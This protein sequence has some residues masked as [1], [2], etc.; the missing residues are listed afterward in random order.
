M[1]RSRNFFS[2]LLPAFLMFIT[3][4]V[5]G[6]AEE[7][8]GYL[9]PMTGI[10]TRVSVDSNG[11]QANLWSDYPS[12][13]GDGRYIAFYSAAGNLVIDDTNESADI[14][15]HDLQLGQTTR[16]SVASDGTQA[17]PPGSQFSPSISADGRFV[18]FDSWASN[19]VSG[20]TNQM[21]DIFVHDRQ[22]GQ[23]TRISVSSD[24]IEGNANSVLPHISADGRFVVFTSYANNL[25]SGDTNGTSDVFLHDMLTVQTTR[26]S[27]S[28]TGIEGNGRSETSFRMAIS[29]DGQY[30]VFG[31]EADN[32]VIGDTN[33][34]YDVFMHNIITGETA[35]I[36]VSSNGAEGDG[37][38]PS[39]SSDGRYVV[40]TS[41]VDNLIS[42]DT[43]GAEDVFL[44][45]MTTGQTTRV[46][47]SSEGIEGNDASLDASISGNGQ[48]VAF[49]SKADNLIEGDTNGYSD[50]FIHDIQIGQ[51]TR[52]SVATD[53][54]EG[55]GNPF[56]DA[57]S[58]DGRYVAF[59]SVASNLV[60]GDTNGE[61]DVFVHDRGGTISSIL[62]KDETGNPISQA[63][64]FQ[65]DDLI[66]ITGADGI[67]SVSNL[68]VNDELVARQLIY[69]A[70]S[71]KDHHDQDASQ[72]WA[73]RVYLTSLDIP[74]NE[75]PTP[76]IVTDPTLMQELVIKPN[77]ALIG[78]N[79]VAS[80]EWDANTAYLNELMAGYQAASAYLY[81]AT[82]GQVLFERVTIYDNNQYMGDADYQ[83]R[84]SNQEWPRANVNGLT[85]GDSLHIFLGRYFDGSSANQGSWEEQNGYRTEIHEFGHYGLGL[86]DSY[87]YYSGFTKLDSNCTSSAIRTNGMW[88]L[89]ATIMDYQYEASEFS[90][91]GVPDLW[92]TQCQNTDQWQQNGE[93]DWETITA[94]FADTNAPPRWELKT[95]AHY[96]GVVAGPH[97]IAVGAW[98]NVIIEGDA[99]T[100]TCEPAPTYLV[101]NLWGDP[102]KGGS[103]VLRKGNQTIAQGKTDDNGEI[104][105]LGASN[106][107]RLI[108][109][110]WGIDLWINSADITCSS[111]LNAVGGS[112]PTSVIT[113]QPASF[114]YFVSVLQGSSSEYVEVSVKASALLSGIPSAYL[115]QHGSISP[116]SIPLSY[117]AQSGAY[118]AEVV[119]DPSLPFSGNVVVVATDTNGQAVEMA[120]PF[121]LE[122]IQ[123]N[124][125]QTVWSADGQAELYVPAGSLSASGRMSVF[126]GQ[127]INSPSENLVLLSGP[128]TIQAEDSL[129]L[130]AP[131]NLGLYYLDLNGTL[132]HA[133]LSSA[134]IYRW[135]GQAWLELTSVSSQNEQVISA[136]IESFGTYAVFAERQEKIY[137]PLMNK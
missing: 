11:W 88:D 72:N 54:T 62:V 104:T 91:Q 28:S 47:V 57:I 98:S 16:V 107:D 24:S 122:T 42:G 89:N 83:I 78:F 1:K 134:K 126:P 20:D 30:V 71:N 29:A 18:A 133:D 81:D 115:T 63:Q 41:D 129:S 35:R 34:L 37:Y 102:V 2:I 64:V 131:A 45:D 93:S 84:A 136:P 58:A 66:G 80:V 76:Y 51:T 105:I 27:V 132:A 82:D 31:S 23:T 4:M 110:L 90:M 5:W 97:T 108:V 117:D 60:S 116:L 48:Y 19:L 92:S 99:N 7:S 6:E 56:F 112:Y 40:F 61:L 127:M 39:I 103:V 111:N 128:Y 85:S 67:V 13:S 52:V 113:L 87:F 135:D 8:T 38:D 96:N 25:V 9:V 12:I 21:L 26:I 106:G 14:F 46:S 125:N 109:H 123:P 32:L 22:T 17:N 118:V 101:E 53:G 124:Q 55:I 50:I 44:H 130:V 10:T 94:Q 70:P 74:Q 15:V 114:T 59:S 33:G 119:L 3:S 65:N 69:E 73:Y 43:N 79:L 121:S 120:T 100:G 75:E 49:L 86:Y 137:L 77:N 68:V 36:S 95:P